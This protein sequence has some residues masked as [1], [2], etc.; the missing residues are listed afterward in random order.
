MEIIIHHTISDLYKTLGLPFN[1][2]IDFTILSIPEIHPEIPFQSPTLRADYFSFILTKEGSGIYW[3]DDHKFPFDSHTIY[4][5]NPG[6]IKSY[7]LYE[8]KDAFIITLSEKF[9]RENVH[10]EIY[11]E[12]PFLLAEIVPPQKLLQ[13]DFEEFET[14]YSQ[15]LKEFNK[16]SEYKNK[17]LGNLFMVILLKIKERFWSTYNPIEEGNSDSQIVKTFKRLLEAV[18]KEVL[19]GTQQ[20]DK[21]QVQDIARIMNLHPNYLNSVIKSKTGRTVNDWISKRILSVA[22]SLLIHTPYS[23]KEIAY[24][25]GFSEATHFSRFFKKHT[26]LSPNTFRKSNKK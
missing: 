2:E 23:S 11:R 3:L 8:S 19:K 26:E 24:K 5:T 15:I 7:E 6:H 10:P 25:L 18:F 13:N 4:F 12:F 9:L 14:L 22:K 17:I 21:L 20:G 16:E 1:Q